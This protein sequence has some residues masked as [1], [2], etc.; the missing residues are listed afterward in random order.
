MCCPGKWCCIRSNRADMGA[1]D[2]AGRENGE[3][4]AREASS[5]LATL[6][7]G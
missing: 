3:R 2:E 1:S 6:M 5:M 7:L 4:A